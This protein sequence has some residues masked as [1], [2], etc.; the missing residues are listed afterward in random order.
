MMFEIKN[1]KSHYYSI[2]YHLQRLYNLGARK[3]V[4][5]NVGPIGCIPSQRDAH[6]AEGDNCITFANQ[7]ALSFNTQLKGLIA[8]LNSN[9]GGSIFVYADIYHILADMLVNYAAFGMYMV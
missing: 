4:V 8:E 9:L 2:L 5:A 6:P 3:I 7:M 1:H